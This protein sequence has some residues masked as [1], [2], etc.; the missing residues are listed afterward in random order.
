MDLNISRH[1]VQRILTKFQQHKTLDDL[2]KSG[3]PQRNDY[4]YERLFIRDSRCHPKK[5]A[6][7]LQ[8]YWRSSKP[9]S[10]S[11]VKS[12]LRKYELLGRIAAKKPF[13][14]KQYIRSRLNWCKAYS[15]V[16]PSLWNDVM[17]IDECRLELFGRRM[18]YVR[19]PKETRFHEKYTT[20]SMKFGGGGVLLW[21]AIE[22]DGTKILIKCPDR[23]NFNGYIDVLNKGLLSIYDRND[24]FKQDN[25]PCHKLRVAS[26][27][28][29]NLWNM[30]FK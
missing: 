21:G 10:V 9:T 23:L 29:D 8:I 2:Q 1:G 4:R 3:R 18:E 20:K 26:S 14:N 15:N 13:L 19:R 12:I 5:T 24:I 30:Q 11:I 27:F 25:A 6:R 17:F 22:E 7:K 16:D 28:I